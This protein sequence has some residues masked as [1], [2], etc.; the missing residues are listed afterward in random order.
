MVRHH[1]IE[2][3]KAHG[4]DA[5]SRDELLIAEGVEELGEDARW[6]GSFAQL[7]EDDQHA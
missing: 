4:L 6:G 5:D 7:S 1:G 3:R 2:F